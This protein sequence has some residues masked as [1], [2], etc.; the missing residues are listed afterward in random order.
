M[1]YQSAVVAF[2]EPPRLVDRG[3]LESGAHAGAQEVRAVPV[4]PVCVEGTVDGTT[5]WERSD[6]T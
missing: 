3:V 5:H 1:T 2:V 6:D 4:R